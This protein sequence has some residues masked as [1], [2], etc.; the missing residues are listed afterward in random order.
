MEEKPS[1]AMQMILEDS[2]REKH[3]DTIFGLIISLILIGW[4]FSTYMIFSYFANS[5]SIHADETQQNAENNGD[6]NSINQRG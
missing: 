1:F 2:K 4:L 5:Y 6:N 3:K